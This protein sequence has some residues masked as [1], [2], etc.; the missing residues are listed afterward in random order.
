M[1]ERCGDREGIMSERREQGNEEICER[2]NSMKK[3][4]REAERV[5]QKRMSERM[6]Q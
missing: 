3:K 5:G 6:K 1:S 2:E 4:V